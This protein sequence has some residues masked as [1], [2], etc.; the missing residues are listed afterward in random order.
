MSI[1]DDSVQQSLFKT[2]LEMLFGLNYVHG[3]FQKLYL[4]FFYL[5]KKIFKYFY[6]LQTRRL[7]HFKPIKH[8]WWRAQQA[9]HIY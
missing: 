5:K 8:V 9:V 1:L 4:A 2:S 6:Q 3:F 7:N